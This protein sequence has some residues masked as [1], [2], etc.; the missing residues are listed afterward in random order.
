M[1]AQTNITQGLGEGDYVVD[2][3]RGPNIQGAIAT[4]MVGSTDDDTEHSPR[5]SSSDAADSSDAKAPDVNISV[6]D[7]QDKDEVMVDAQGGGGEV[8]PSVEAHHGVLNGN[9]PTVMVASKLG[10]AQV[11]DVQARKDSG[12]LSDSVVSNGLV[13]DTDRLVKNGGSR[14]RKPKTIHYMNSRVPH[15]VP[16]LE[17]EEGSDGQE[18][19]EEGDTGPVRPSQAP[20][21]AA[22]KL[23]SMVP[24]GDKLL[25]AP[26]NAKELMATRLMEG[27]FVRCSCRGIQL[28]GMLK[29]M[30]VRCDCR[31]CKSSVIV[32]I[33]AFEAHSG[34]TSHHPSDNIYLENGKNLRDI[35]SAGQE[36]AD[37]GDNILRALKMAIGDIQG[38]EK[39]KVTCA[40][41]WNSDEGDLIYCKGARCSIIAHSRCI[42]ISNPRLG[43]WF[44][45]KCEKMKKPHATVKVKR[46]ISSGTE[47]DDGRVRE[48]DATESTRLN[49]DAH[50]HK[51]LFLPGG[52]EDGTELGYYTKSQLKLKGVK[53]GEGISCSCCDKEIN[54]YKFEQHAGCEARRNP[55]GNILLVAD[56]RSLKDVCKELAHKNKLGEK[57]KR[58]ARAGKVNS[59]YECGT[60]GELKN[61]HGCVETWCNSCT[62]GL[63]TDSD[64]KWY[65]RM[66]RQDTLNVAQIEQKRSNK[67]IEGM[68]NI[69]ETDERDRCVRHLEGHRE[70]GGCAICK[71]WNLSKTG[72]VDGMTILVC[73][74]CG[75][76]YHVSC[77]KDSGVD[78]LNELPE[79]EWF[80]QKDCKVIDEILTQLVAN[81]PELLTD[82]IISELL[83]SRQQQTGAKDKAESSC[84]SFA[85]QILC[86]KSGNTA[87]TQT[88]AEAIN[89]FTECSDPIRDAK[90][91]KNLI[92]LMVQS[93]RSKDHDFEGVFCIVL[94]LNEKVVSAALLQIFGG[95]IA[96]VPL[97]ATSLTHQGQGFCKALMTTIERLLGVLSVERLVLPTA[98]NTES[99]WINKFGFS[100]VPDDELK[101]ICTTIR[102]M[103]FTGTC[104]LGKAITPMTV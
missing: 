9:A 94:K 87:N 32:S 82:S 33:S 59:C 73:D 102:L 43:D 93:R 21:A 99:I 80:C 41:C 40:K 70:V 37:C 16:T 36:A 67:H 26:R 14:K 58:V 98:K 60:R 51:A 46:S 103:T 12:G 17:S 22:T 28:T 104:M 65:C 49:R 19:H 4:K 29:D 48:K 1:G 68:S 11:L 47:K 84:P 75:R 66:C 18:S 91:G 88:L 8:S 61:C 3:G 25:K 95:E 92:P 15:S 7:H 97:V 31:N 53:R 74:Q 76:E 54:C 27:H 5:V 90:T 45:D 56:G 6:L 55:Y 101:K 72:F 2:A 30:G 50:L 96:E 77:L 69:A 44:C 79:G 20:R 57:E 13:H 64:G 63:E 89:I 10:E 35:L 38:V 100:R 24:I 81:G 83:E 71:K 34:S 42:G 39:W 23:K 62:K 86:G 85:W 52:L 78:D